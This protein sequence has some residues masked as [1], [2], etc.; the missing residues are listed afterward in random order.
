[1]V[2]PL[3]HKTL[4]SLKQ[5]AR[6]RRTE[7]GSVMNNN[8][9]KPVAHRLYLAWKANWYSR[10]KVGKL[11]GLRENTTKKYEDGNCKINKYR[12]PKKPL[13]PNIVH[14]KPKASI[15]TQQK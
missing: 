8:F 6:C 2:L 7:A 5:A 14:M 1:M 9:N 4:Q 3:C 11:I 13:A 10:E 15:P 12:T